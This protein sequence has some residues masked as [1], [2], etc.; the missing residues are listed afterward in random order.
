MVTFVS[1]S[2]CDDKP[3]QAERCEQS[4]KCEKRGSISSIMNN[5]KLMGRRFSELSSRVIQVTTS[6]EQAWLEEWNRCRFYYYLMAFHRLWSYLHEYIILK[7][8]LFSSIKK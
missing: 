5:I 7:H 1:E 3:E 2:D 8:F 6:T 4:Y